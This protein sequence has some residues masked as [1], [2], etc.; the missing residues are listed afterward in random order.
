MKTNETKM[1]IEMKELV[2]TAG[3]FLSFLI[4]GM[5][6]FSFFSPT[7]KTNAAN[8]DTVHV[9]ATINPVLSVAVSASE[10][11]IG[12]VNP[13][14]D[15]VFASK[16]G[17]VTVSTNDTA[18]YK[19]YI[20][21]NTSDVNLT[22]STTDTPIAPCASNVTSS[23]MAKDSWGYSINSGSTFNPITSSN[24]QIKNWSGIAGGTTDTPLTV[25]FGAKIS[26]ATKAGTYSNVVKFTGIV[27]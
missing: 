5:L 16:S 7:I 22:S 3:T 6:V 11:S 12:T 4:L 23:T 27:N 1:G 21:S 20:S 14:T 19:L 13:N 18:G 24:V 15:G 2:L 25:Y 17:T 8:S 10:I 9:S 26:T